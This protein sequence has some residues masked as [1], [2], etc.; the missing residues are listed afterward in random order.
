MTSKMNLKFSPPSV[1]DD[2]YRVNILPIYNPSAS[3]VARKSQNKSK[4]SR[5]SEISESEH[6]ETTI[7]EIVQSLKGK[8]D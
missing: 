3:D 6:T 1:E 8:T 5:L 2:R 7:I 4:S